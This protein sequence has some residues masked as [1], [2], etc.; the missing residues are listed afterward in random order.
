MRMRGAIAVVAIVALVAPSLARAAP[1]PAAKA[2]AREHYTAARR[3][4]DL[5]KWEDAIVE[6]QAAYKLAS[7]PELLFNIGQCYRLKG[8]KQRAI[9]AYQAYLAAA[10]DGAA[11]DEAHEHVATLQLRIEVE[12][13]EAISR[14][15]AQEAEAARRQAVEAEAARRRAEAEM[16]T[17]HRV[18]LEQE[19]RA[20]QQAVAAEAAAREK[21]EADVRRRT[22]AAQRVG[23][24]ERIVGP[25]V[26]GAGVLIGGLAFT[27]ILDANNQDDIIRRANMSGWTTQADAAIQQEKADTRAMLGMW[28]TG[29]ILAVGGMVV[30]IVGYKRRSRALERAGAGGAL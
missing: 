28:I 13:A 4:Q 22:A 21:Q 30:T 26:L 1:T 18:A 6:Y 14:R 29:G 23:R 20:R 10:P 3:L 11:A 15:A 12:R 7:L 19:A 9:D 27:V 24:I 8:D 2:E 5:G 25:S 16:E 17:R